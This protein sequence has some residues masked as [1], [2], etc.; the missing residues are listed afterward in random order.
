VTFFTYARRNLFRN[1]A[2]VILTVLGVVI[3]VL[4][5]VMLRTVL[6]S[7]SAAV[8]HAAKDRLG[9][10]HKQSFT[11]QLPLKYVEDLKQVKGVTSAT[12]CNWF[13]GQDPRDKSNFFA[14]LACDHHTV[15]DVLNDLSVTPAERQAWNDTPNGAIVG[16]VLARKLGKKVGDKITLTGTIYPGDWEFQIVGIYKATSRAVDRSQFLFR[17]DYVNKDPRWIMMGSENKVGWII[18]RIDD[19]K[20]SA[21][22]AK[23]IDDKFGIE[24]EQTLTMSERA[25]NLS[26]LG[27]ISMVLVAIDAVSIVILAIMALILGNTIAM[28]VRERTHEYAVMRAI[29]FRPG[30]MFLFVLLESV[31]TGLLGGAIGLVLSYGLIQEGLGSALEENVGQFFPYFDIEPTTALAAVILSVLLGAVAALIPAIRTARLRV[32]EALR[33]VA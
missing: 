22:I 5:F 17:W 13:G 3:A 27:M 7:W 31:I 2:R 6:S 19:G 33:R 9:T 21:A 25:M 10:R 8:D 15:L 28:G 18:S 1:R 23:A 11:F 29:G 16:D 20:N 32:V 26:F 12:W 4:V 30:H 14:T 24:D